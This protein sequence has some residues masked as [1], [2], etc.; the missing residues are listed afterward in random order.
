MK[1]AVVSSPPW[2]LVLDK[3]AFEAD[4]FGLILRDKKGNL[5]K[6][7]EIGLR[8]LDEFMTRYGR[9]MFYEGYWERARPGGRYRIR[10]RIMR[11]LLPL[12]KKGGSPIGMEVT[13]TIR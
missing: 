13:M 11:R 6:E 12:A 5:V 7:A 4:E 3:D 8:V 2:L 9:G 10:G 1:E